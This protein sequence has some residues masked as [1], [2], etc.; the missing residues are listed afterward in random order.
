M[1]LMG[2][3]KMSDEADLGNE[4]AE[5]ILEAIISE[6]RYQAEKEKA[7]GS[8]WPHGEGCCKNCG[9]RL[10]TEA[11]VMEIRE[12]CAIMPSYCDEACRDDHWKRICASKRRGKE[13]E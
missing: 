6:T 9:E 12:E 11:E 2:G 8:S 10:V 5:K 13:S 3:S 7:S 4:R 1:E